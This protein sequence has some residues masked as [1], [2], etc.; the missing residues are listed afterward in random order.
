MGTFSY[1]FLFWAEMNYLIPAQTGNGIMKMYTNCKLILSVD[2][3]SGTEQLRVLYSKFF[4][5]FFV[6]S[7][8][9]PTVSQG[10]LQTM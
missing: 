5:D 4:V 10:V 6:M 1:P 9:S 8:L 2:S 7:L 3:I